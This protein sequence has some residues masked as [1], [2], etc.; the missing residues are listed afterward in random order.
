MP[1]GEAELEEIRTVLFGDHMADLELL[2]A[3]HAGQ[4]AE[5][6]ARIAELEAAVYDHGRRSELV[7]EVLADA[8]SGQKALAAFQPA[9][10]PE[11][12]QAILTSS[13][14]DSS[15]LAEALYPVIGPAVRKMITNMFTIDGRNAGQTFLIE[16]MLL[17]DR[18]TGLV[19]A[20]SAT[21]Q[22]M[23]EDADV[24]SGMIDAIRRFV[25]E[26]FDADDHDGLRD[27]RVGDTSVLVE[28]GPKCVLASVVRGVPD[29]QFRE[30]VAALLERIHLSHA[31]EL[32]H[33]SGDIEPFESAS[34]ELSTLHVDTSDRVTPSSPLQ[35]ARGALTRILAFILFVV[36]IVLLMWGFTQ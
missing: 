31:P 11:V 4:L 8:V 33:F 3:E 14:D 20:A 30:R 26:A 27:L 36:L 29:D 24:I 7:S 25:Q 10:K 6:Q 2:R 12:E 22:E 5:M 17:I 34:L 32:E 9:L 18:Q 21:E 1:N 19:L 35:E 28:W 23:L 15:V 16:Q 13:R